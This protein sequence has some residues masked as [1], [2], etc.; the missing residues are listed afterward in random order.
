MIEERLPRKATISLRQAYT[1]FDLLTHWSILV[2]DQV[3][4]AEEKHMKLASHRESTWLP[5]LSAYTQYMDC[6]KAYA[7]VMELKT[8]IGRQIELAGGNVSWDE[9]RHN[10]EDQIQPMQQ[11]YGDAEI[12]K[13]NLV[14]MNN[15]MHELKV[16]LRRAGIL[17]YRKQ[18][19]WCRGK[20]RP[21][22]CSVP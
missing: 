14:W 17:M 19:T 18:N 22:C 21:C 20:S 9:T 11:L 15:G 3:L 13:I 4:L 12:V 7:A 2:S 5:H 10:D 8:E 1:A 16:R 6:L